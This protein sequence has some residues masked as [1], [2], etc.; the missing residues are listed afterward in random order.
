MK[1]EGYRRLVL[2][3]KDRLF[4]YAAYLLGDVEEARDVAQEALVRLWEH[5]GEIVVSASARA[6]LMRT[7]HNLC[8]DRLRLRAGRASIDLQDEALERMPAGRNGSPERAAS[9]REI[10]EAITRALG[11][12]GARDRSVLLLREVDGMSYGEIAMMLGLPLGTLK[13]V[14]HRAREKLRRLLT[15]EGVR[16]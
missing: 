9:S 15:Q 10:G 16:P 12:L 7:A 1:T 3:T 4:T 8:M 6:W 11:D 14:L 2:E 13:A 5:R